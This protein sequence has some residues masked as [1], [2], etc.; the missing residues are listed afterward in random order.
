MDKDVKAST[1]DTEENLSE[2]IDEPNIS[3]EEIRSE[4]RPSEE[5]M[6]IEESDEEDIP[7]SQRLDKRLRL[8][9]EENNDPPKQIE[10]PIIENVDKKIN[11]S[12]DDEN[13]DRYISDGNNDSIRFRRDSTSSGATTTTTTKQTTKKQQKK[14]IIRRSNERTSNK[15]SMASKKINTPI[16]KKIRL[17]R[18]KPSP[19]KR[20]NQPIIAKWVKKYGI[21]DCYVRLNLYD[22][23][24]ENGRD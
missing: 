21:E 13:Q 16:K 14:K 6:E 17:V 5:E 11:I 24:Y 19:C 3:I 1:T 22:P 8:S 10:I 9:K 4:K 20:S 18:K 15:S 2:K 12:D 23:V 7:V